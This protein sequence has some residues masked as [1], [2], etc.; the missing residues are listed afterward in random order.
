VHAARRWRRVP[1]AGGGQRLSVTVVDREAKRHAQ[2]ICQRY[3]RLETVCDLVARDMDVTS[4][5]FTTREFLSEVEARGQ[6][7]SVYICLDDAVRGLAAALALHRLLHPLPVPGLDGKAEQVPIVVRTTERAGLA[8]LLGPEGGGHP[9]ESLYG[10]SLLDEVCRPHKLLHETTNEVLARAIHADYVHHQRRAGQTPETN[11]SVVDWDELPETLKES[12]RH[13]A[14]H[15]GVALA[16]IGCS[17]EPTRDW[18]AAELSLTVEEV[19][20]MAR[21]EH[22][23][24]WRER[25]ACGWRWGHVK[26]VRR[27]LSP[28]L[29]PWEELSE[30]ARE[31][32]RNT[33]RGIP[34]F[35]AQAGFSVVR[36]RPRPGTPGRSP[37]TLSEG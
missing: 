4:R 35:L 14:G 32:D 19:E 10:F 9:Y 12:N 5:E 8:M 24:W 11:P 33:V 28:D 15:I 23:R 37:S 21:M 18:D 2:S 3:P 25:E 26:D 22:E 1:P 27:K 34:A 29:A 30:E 36:S 6:V 7:T 17:I 16:R 20:L 31:K 13:Q